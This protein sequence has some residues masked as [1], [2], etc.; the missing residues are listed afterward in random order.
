VARERLYSFEKSVTCSLLRK[1][2]YTHMAAEY[3]CYSLL[4]DHILIAA[5]YRFYSLLRT[6]GSP[7]TTG[8]SP[9]QGRLMRSM[10][11]DSQRCSRPAGGAENGGRG[12]CMRCKR[13]GTSQ[14]TSKRI[15]LTAPSPRAKQIPMG[16]KAFRIICS[17]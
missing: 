2:G 13:Q 9:S 6:K 11:H 8:D 17:T 10:A 7:E 16:A 1:I 15:T 3:R 5:K 14:R 4:R 12:A